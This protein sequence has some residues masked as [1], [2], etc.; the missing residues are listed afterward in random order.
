MV[1]CE[2]VIADGAKLFDDAFG[3]VDLEE[4]RREF[5]GDVA[6]ILARIDDA[7]NPG[8]MLGDFGVRDRDLVK[9]FG[10]LVE[11]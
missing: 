6:W 1:A 8:K 11:G 2:G 7:K 5:E 9:F 3:G 4:A 10:V